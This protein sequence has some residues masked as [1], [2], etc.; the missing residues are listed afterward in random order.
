MRFFSSSALARAPKL[1]FA[2]SC[3]A[4]E[5]M[6]WL[7]PAVLAP[8]PLMGRS[9]D[10]GH[11]LVLGFDKSIVLFADGPRS[12]GDDADVTPP[13]PLP[14]WPEPGSSPCR[15]PSRPR[16]SRISRRHGPRWRVWPSV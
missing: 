14:S 7:S 2:A 11:Y 9:A 6:F 13:R 1:R 15:R 4:A 10:A 5:T 16:Q 3:S 8:T 12:A